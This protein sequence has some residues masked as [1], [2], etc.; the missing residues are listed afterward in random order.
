MPKVL[1]HADV[2]GL[3]G[4]RGSRDFT[5]AL[6]AERVKRLVPEVS[7]WTVRSWVQRNSIP[8]EFWP[9][10]EA[11]AASC[12]IDGVTIEGLAIAAERQVK[13]EKDKAA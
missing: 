13:R 11:A 1:S 3:W 10:V 4:G 2:I 7:Y 9:A 8:G 6:N 5:A 12:G